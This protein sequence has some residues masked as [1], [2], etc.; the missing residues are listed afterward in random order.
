[1]IWREIAQYRQNI[2]AELRVESMVVDGDGE[3]A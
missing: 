3:V 2:N 1:M